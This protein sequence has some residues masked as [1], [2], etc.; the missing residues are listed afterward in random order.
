MEENKQEQ[1]I[2]SKSKH[3]YRFYLALV[4]LAMPVAV[5][6]FSYAD[7]SY[8]LPLSIIFNMLLLPLA[9]IFIYKVAAEKQVFLRAHDAFIAGVITI[10]MEWALALVITRSI[11]YPYLLISVA[12]PIL[13]T[14]VSCCVISIT[15]ALVRKKKQDK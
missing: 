1:K 11:Y 14:L 7:N 5:L 9:T 12:I 6:A 3:R 8:I 4:M 2:N 13:Y 10:I 15:F